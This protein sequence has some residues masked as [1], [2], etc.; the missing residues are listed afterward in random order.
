MKQNLQLLAKVQRV[1]RE[2]T[3]TD[4]VMSYGTGVTVPERQAL[5]AEVLAVTDGTPFEDRAL[6]AL[7]IS[8]YNEVANIL[9][10]FSS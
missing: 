5:C 1:A 6:N 10:E 4:E 8:D 3:A 2:L 7:I 9:R